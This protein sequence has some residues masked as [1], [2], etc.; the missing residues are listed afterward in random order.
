MMH[1]EM[2]KNMYSMILFPYQKKK[3]NKSQKDPL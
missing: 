3:E 1:Y 2:K